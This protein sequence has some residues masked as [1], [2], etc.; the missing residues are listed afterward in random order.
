MCPCPSK[1]TFSPPLLLLFPSFILFPSFTPPLPT[2]SPCEWLSAPIT[3]HS[4]SLTRRQDEPNAPSLQVITSRTP[5]P[6]HL[7]FSLSPYRHCVEPSSPTNPPSCRQAAKTRRAISR[8]DKLFPRLQDAVRF[9]A[10]PYPAHFQHP[11]TRLQ[12]SRR[13]AATFQDDCVVLAH[14]AQHCPPPP[15][16]TI[17]F[18]RIA[19]CKSTL[20][21]TSPANALFNS[22]E[23]KTICP[24]RPQHSTSAPVIP[25]SHRDPVLLEDRVTFRMFAIRVVCRLSCI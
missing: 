3:A 2:P 16:F 22:H 8:P 5:Y 9:K 20:L 7:L 17:S 6:G 14:P 15:K 18:V 4:K 12:A 24:P 11:I 23:I 19:Y 25:I 21:C 10:S 1:P 13:C